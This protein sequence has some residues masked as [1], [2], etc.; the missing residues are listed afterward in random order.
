MKTNRYDL[1]LYS[2]IVVLEQLIHNALYN[3]TRVYIARVGMRCSAVMKLR[4]MI[5]IDVFACVLCI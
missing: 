4:L 2:Y 1:I 5:Q 3:N